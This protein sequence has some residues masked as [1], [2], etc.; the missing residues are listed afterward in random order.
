MVPV[1]NNN[2]ASS[3]RT[4]VSAVRGHSGFVFITAHQVAPPKPHHNPL[5]ARF[6]CY[7]HQDQVHGLIGSL[8][9]EPHSLP[10]AG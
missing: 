9:E 6:S 10:F 7:G 5:L 8:P 4:T 2:S 3:R 1:N